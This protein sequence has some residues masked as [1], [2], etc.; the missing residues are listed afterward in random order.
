MSYN[1]TD[2]GSA[3]SS[4]SI[5]LLSANHKNMAGVMVGSPL[6]TKPQQNADNNW[7]Q[8]ND[9]RIVLV[10]KTGVGKS[11]AA[12]T[13][14]GRKAFKAQLCA[15]SVTEDCD[16]ERGEVNGRDVAVVDTPGLFDT[17]H[18]NDEIIREIV[19]CISLSSPGPHVFVV[20]IQLGRFTQEEQKTVEIIQ[21]TFGAESA[22]YTMVLFTH[23]DDLDGMS[24]EDFISNS[25]LSDFVGQCHGGYHVFNNK[26]MENRSQVTQLLQ[27][28][29]KM[30]E[31][32]GGCCYTNKMYEEAEAAIQA[33]IRRGKSR[34]Q[35]E[36]DNIF[37]EKAIKAVERIIQMFLEKQEAAIKSAEKQNELLFKYLTADMKS[38]EEV[39]KSRCTIQ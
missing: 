16:K 29:D 5:S 15:S 34:E 12:N 17:K 33:E 1:S 30:V 38:R 21:E 8:G 25:K 20:V 22:K 10:G 32:N 14:L 23:G 2:I 4:L 37:L 11:A 9:L 18:S 31:G 24:I 13:I 36:R 19:N 6:G 3:L 7:G 27:K 35:A 28:I 26:D 39:K